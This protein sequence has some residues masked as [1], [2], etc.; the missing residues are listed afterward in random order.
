M[1]STSRV[2]E[3]VSL[4]GK[5]IH[6]VALAPLTRLRAIPDKQVHTD[7]AATYY[8]Q[9]ASEGGLLITEATFIAREAGGYPYAPG[10]YSAEQIAAWK[11]VTSAVHAKG[12]LIYTQLWALGRANCD[13]PLHDH[14]KDVKTVGVS[15]IGLKDEYV[16][17]E[18][19]LDD[20]K[21]YI[22]HYGQASLNAVEAGMDGVE[23]HGAN[24]YLP[25][26]FLQTNS[27]KRT[28]IYGCASLENR[29]RFLLE[30][31]A[32]AVNAIG[33]ERVGVRLSPW[34]TF[35]GMGEANPFEI[36]EYVV[37]QLVER[38]PKLAYLHFVEPREW[39]PGS[40]SVKHHNEGVV[41][42]NDRFRAIVRG[43]D[44]D[45]IEVDKTVFPDPTPEHPIVFIS[46]SGF[47][48]ENV[49]PHVQRTG[50][51]AAFGRL[52]I[53][54]PDLPARIKSHTP[55]TH[56]NRDTF[57]VHGPEGYIDYPT[58]GEKA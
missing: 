40:A 25:D 50:D 30:A 22:G 23:I 51:V 49:G 39:A 28:D 41:P 52:F 17:E 54:N 44:P 24:G 31:V 3:P 2:F 47:D 32:S 43:M 29:A 38:F 26:Q 7:L 18:L 46:A 37:K 19:S 27:N 48:L 20:I 15:P 8:G 55:L 58:A 53:S 34:G 10:M 57:Y 36:F 1:A 14:M 45:S 9:R 35:Q 16:P 21:R 6:R 11:K 33:A 5:K 12:G 13:P 4:G 42:S 56:Y